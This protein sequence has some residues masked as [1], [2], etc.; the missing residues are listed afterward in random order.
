MA[1]ETMDCKG[2][3][4]RTGRDGVGKVDVRY[5]IPVTDVA[6]GNVCNMGSPWM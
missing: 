2:H 1:V 4:D 6:N 3:C 5:F